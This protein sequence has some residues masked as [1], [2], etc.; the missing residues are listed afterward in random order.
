MRQPETT[1][2]S[3]KTEEAAEAMINMSL[4]FPV[5]WYPRF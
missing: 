2:F 4:C 1:S 5:L 3:E